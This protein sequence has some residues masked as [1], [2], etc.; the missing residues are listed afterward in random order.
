MS[1][2]TSFLKDKKVPVNQY[3]AGLV[4][5]LQ[6]YARN[7]YKNRESLKLAVE[8]AL[9]E[10]IRLLDAEDKERLAREAGL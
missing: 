10:E 2:K 7:E 8:Q 1:K 3:V 6:E 5:E 9:D 4:D